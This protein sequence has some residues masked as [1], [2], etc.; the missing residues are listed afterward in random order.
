M[1]SFLKIICSTLLFTN[2]VAGQDF[3]FSNLNSSNGLSD[4]FVR[5][6][7]VDKNGFLWIGTNFGLNSYDGYS[8]TNYPEEDHPGIPSRAI[9]HMICDKENNLWMGSDEGACVADDRRKFHR[10]RLQDSIK[11]YK[12][13]YIT[14][15]K[16]YGV[17]LYTDRGQFVQNKQNKKW[18]PINW[19]PEKINISGLVELISYNDDKVIVADDSTVTMLDYTNQK[20]AF[21]K[22][23][24]GLQSACR[25]INNNLGLVY[26]SGLIEIVD[27]QNG[28]VV[29]QLELSAYAKGRKG[30][31]SWSEMRFAD[32]DNILVASNLFGFFVIDKNF[33]VSSPVHNEADPNS[34]AANEIIRVFPASSGNVVLGTYRAGVSI[35]N[36]LLKKAGYQRFF[37][38]RNM[39]IYAGPIGGI[40]Q[41][42]EGIFWAA[43]QERLM[44]WDRKTNLADFFYYT[45]KS[46]D[47]RGQHP[48][49]YRVCVDKHDQVWVSLMN[50]GI[51]TLDKNTRQFKLLKKDILNNPSVKSNKIY[52]ILASSDDRIWVAGESGLYT[53]NPVTKEVIT[54]NSHP[55]LN[56]A[57]NYITH[58][59]VEDSRKRIWFST[60]NHGLFCYD[61]SK[62]RLKQFTMKDG[63][64]DSTCYELFKDSHD[65]IYVTIQGGFQIVSP[66]GKIKTYNRSNGLKYE[67]VSSV[68]EDDIGN[69]WIANTKALLRLNPSTNKIDAFEQSANFYNGFRGISPI[70]LNT[71]ELIWGTQFGI[72]YFHPSRLSAEADPLSVCIYKVQ[73]GDSAFAALDDKTARIRY[74]DNTVQ[75]DFAGI[76]LSGSL[77]VRYRFMLEGYDKNWQEVKDIRQA[78][79]SSLLPGKYTFRIMASITG[80]D[81]I[82][83]ANSFSFIITRPVH[84]QWWFKLALL[85]STV[86]VLYYFFQRR[87]NLLRQKKEELDAEQAVNYFSSSL[88]EHHTTEDI[89]WDVARNCIGRLQFEDC[90]IYLFD[91]E[92]NVLVQKAA[93][94]Q[95]SP[96]NF[97]IAQPMDIPVGK[98]IVGTVAQT[99]KPEIIPDTSKDKRYIADDAV[100]LSEIAVPI[101]S[102]GK[103]IGI[104]DCEHSKKGFFTQKHLS[105]LNTI[106]SLCAS[107]ISR[108]KTEIEKREAEKMLADTKQKM[109]EAEMQALRAQMN[110]HFIFNCLNSINRYI[111]KSDQATASLYLTRFAKLIR[112]ILD[113]SHSKNV[114]LSNEIEALKLYIDMESL[115][116]DKKFTY[117]IKIEDNVPADS[118]EVPPLIIQPYIENAI[119][120]GLL[121]KTEAGH[122]KINISLPDENLLQCVIEDN[123]V[124][125]EKAAELKSKSAT[126]KK[127]LGME[128]TENRL[129][130]LNQYASVHSSVEIED[131]K[132]ATGAVTG[133]KVIL[134][135]PFGDS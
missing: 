123:G 101:I 21:R 36:V 41:D 27:I 22:K 53:I 3:Y 130:L 8:I 129:L 113:N 2:S 100:R 80:K 70:K 37:H 52:K 77:N 134:K 63:L 57:C 5:S 125:R 18:E 76:N 61:P 116:F 75:F 43:A 20:I 38:T 87:N 46:A 45:N 84:M 117:T 93:H 48:D 91:K 102:D 89:L 126:K 94:G 109:A 7:A 28:N 1:N 35:F 11:K 66:D 98:G 96:R 105:I 90:V 103:L 32:G 24:H 51:A 74:R 88:Y 118:I 81:W 115:R 54:F 107:K 83:S 78:R 13:S 114:I 62:S 71:G 95:K 49:V 97:E 64:A 23:V 60:R 50:I 16:K 133:T 65:N 17:I 29:R 122:L 82:N 15:T 79:Y 47:I 108:A 72:N 40:V 39:E 56:K 106:A 30:L 42:K 34:I 135:I 55:V 68:I 19:E 4:N 132:D 44:K 86:A 92:K 59:I 10:I 112:L 128:L 85:I 110:P 31:S 26:E 12:C 124:G 119:W 69:I 9:I 67:W 104:I 6:L 121:H 58:N 120:H 25:V 73:A 111:V 99:M 127:S 131:I 14:E 33:N